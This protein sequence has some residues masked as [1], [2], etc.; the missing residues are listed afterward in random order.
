MKVG[1]APKK[2]VRLSEWKR[3]V[4]SVR[5]EANRT[6]VGNREADL[7]IAQER[8]GSPDLIYGDFVEL[9]L[10]RGVGG[11]WY[12]D[13]GVYHGMVDC[14]SPF[15]GSWVMSMT[16]SLKSKEMRFPNG[17]NGQG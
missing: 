16:R 9:G 5:R 3:L 2:S 12:L 17:R 4:K 10:D 7:W 11:L 15:G 14:G 1:K 13:G 8:W 6:E